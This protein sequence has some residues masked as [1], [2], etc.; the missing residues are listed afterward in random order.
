M[1]NAQPMFIG[2]LLAILA[3]AGMSAVVGGGFALARRRA[4]QSK[5]TPLLAGD[6][7]DLLLERPILELRVGDIIQHDGRDYLVEGTVAYNEDGHRWI[8][9]RIVDGRDEYWLF[10]GLERDAT[11]LG[12][13]RQDT[14]VEIVGYPT[15]TILV[16]DIQ[17]RLDV[18]GTA[19]GMFDGDVGA[20]PKPRGAAPGQ[21]AERCRWW[22]YKGAGDALLIVEQWGEIYRVLLGRIVSKTAVEMIPG[23]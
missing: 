19:N 17:F 23:S 20:M 7:Q 10:V 15:D 6:G 14:S 8:G 21:P 9:G 12:W 18:R 5:N 1:D 11:A 22:R 13:L 2:L 4:L 3:I 16:G